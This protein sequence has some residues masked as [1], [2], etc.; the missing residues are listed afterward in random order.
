M[1]NRFIFYAEFDEALKELPDKQRLKIYDA[2]CDYALREIEPNLLGVEKVVFS[3]IKPKLSANLQRSKNGSKGG[4]PKNNQNARKVVFENNQETTENQPKNN[5]ETTENQ[6]NAT[7]KETSPPDKESSK[8]I[9]P[10]ERKN[11][12]PTPQGAGE[13]SSRKEDFFEKYP[14]LSGRTVKDEGID[15]G[16][17]I[18]EFE[19]SSMLRGLYSFPKVVAMYS[20]IERGDFRD[21]AKP[22]AISPLVD[23][24]NAR[25]LR[26][27][28]YADK[29]AKA[30]AA[31]DKYRN[32]ASGSQR[33]LQI[34]RAIARL[35]LELA[36]ASINEPNRVLELEIEQVGY[37]REREEL[38]EHLGIQEWQLLPQYECKKCSDSG[39][40]PNGRACDCYKGE[41]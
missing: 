11:I 24:A 22:A 28:Y 27:K 21:K 2:I 32:I 9:I 20:A 4:A 30:E 5:Q 17:L 8:E 35:N 15:Y 40:L 23:A 1:Q 41:T 25:S 39:F 14:A 13:T 10:S 34:E 29:R 7:K 33:F 19:L 31:A 3:L 6:A 12:P 26:D 37:L 38:L 18:R 36:K 16:V